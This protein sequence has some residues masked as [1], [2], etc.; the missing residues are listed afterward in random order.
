MQSNEASS[1]EAKWEKSVFGAFL[2]FRAGVRS[3]WIEPR[4]VL[5]KIREQD[6]W[7]P[8]VFCVSNLT[9]TLHL[10]ALRTGLKPTPFTGTVHHG[11]P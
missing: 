7:V 2:S 5:A 1:G 6:G 3:R 8:F 9:D 10:H 4:A 11:I